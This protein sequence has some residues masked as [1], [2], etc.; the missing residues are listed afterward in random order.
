MKL[1]CLIP[2][3]DEEVTIA[4][5][6]AA[7]PRRVPGFDEVEVIVIDDGSRDRTAEVAARAGAQVVS[8]PVNLGVGAAFHTGIDRA[9]DRGADAVVTLD[10][11]GQ[12]DPRHIPRLI[13]PIRDGRAGM[14]TASR[15]LDPSLVPRMPRA[16]RWGNA[17]MAWLVSLLTGR[18]FH[19]VSCGYRAYSR[20]AA[21][22]LN[23]FGHFTY[24]QETFLDLTAKKIPIVEVPLP[25]RGE[26]ESGESR[27]A[28]NLSR[29]AWMTTQ[30]IVRS[31]IDF[32]PLQV[33]GSIAAVFLLPGFALLAFLVVH[34]LR[35][36]AFSP[37][38]AFG[39]AGGLLVSIGVVVLV[40]ALV[41]DMLLRVRLNQE[42]ILFLLKRGRPVPR[43]A[44][45]Q[46]APGDEEGAGEEVGP[47]GEAEEEEEA[48]HHPHQPRDDEAPRPLAEHG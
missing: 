3:Y 24:T 30:I 15:F 38:K 46:A 17:G 37:Y 29:Y 21:L 9:L 20:Q 36:G 14:V 6:I 42:R 8:H 4:A 40:T 11:D 10:A 27:V 48:G 33:I 45:A 39:F 18:R 28:S 26:R 41:A 5:V 34:L 22:H 44:A 43:Q 13:A 32:R 2:A 16:K 31:V 47:G 23:L 7:I 35:T 12:F 19:D 1:V 25:I